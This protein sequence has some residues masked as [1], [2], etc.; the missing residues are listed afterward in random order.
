MDEQTQLQIALSISKE[1]AKKVKA[2]RQQGILFLL[3]L[4]LFT[5]TSIKMDKA[6][7]LPPITKK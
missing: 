4:L 3:L 1:D 2:Y 7:P 6:S 5:L